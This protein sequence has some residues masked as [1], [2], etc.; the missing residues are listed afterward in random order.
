[1][2]PGGHGIAAAR[3]GASGA[4]EARLRVARE[5]FALAADFS[6]SPGVTALLGP[7]GAG[8]STVVAAL[9]GL[10]PLSGGRVVADGR[11]WEDVSAGVR[12]PPRERRVGVAFQEPRLLPALTA[13]DN[14][15]YGPRARGIA[16]PEARRRAADWLERLDAGHLASRR[17][18][19]L[20]GG[21]AQRVALARALAADADV[22]L[23]DEPLSAQDVEARAA[24][25][26]AL[27]ESL[28][29]F[30]G[31][32][33]IVTH[34]PVEAL[35][36]AGRV[37]VIE[38]GRVVQQGDAEALRRRPASPWVAALA[39]VNLLRG[40]LEA[41]EGEVVLACEGLRLAVLPGD[42]APGAEAAAV[43]S[44]RAITLSIDPP[45]S[46]A[47]NVIAG[48]VAS[49]DPGIDRIR[50]TLD[51]RPPLTAE[52]TRESLAGLGIAPGT[53]LYAAVKVTEIELFPA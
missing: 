32:A 39:G 40:R 21:E 5:G 29:A 10:L 3:A 18:A 19:G 13:L 25:R 35:T 43:V 15:A 48:A 46:S 17:P 9:A 8:K 44:P 12:L 49:V 36:L 33:L 24:S 1:M 23:L 7:N 28:S 31:V 16:R 26:R 11:V 30:E 38:A 50:V 53:R 37:A 2:S 27:A 22:L 45:R 4:L 51:T 47:R 42:L 14:V 52:I 34:D 20:S 41:A 6:A